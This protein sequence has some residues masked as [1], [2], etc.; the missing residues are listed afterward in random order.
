MI[1]RK[2]ASFMVMV[3]LLASLSSGCKKASPVENT[4]SAPESSTTTESTTE[5]TSA[6]TSE[7]SV[8]TTATT[9][10]TEAPETEDTSETEPSES[11]TEPSETSEKAPA[12][13]TPKET[14]ETT[15]A[16]E[17][18][19]DG[20]ILP[21]SGDYI[22]P[23]AIPPEITD[24]IERLEY[25]RSCVIN[26]TAYYDSLDNNMKDTWC[27]Q[28][29]SDHSQ[30]GSYEYFRISDYN[31]FYINKNVSDEDKVIYLTFD[32]GYASNL[33]GD[34]LDI[35]A[36][37]NAKANFFVT[38]NYLQGCSGYAIR[39]KEEG[40]LVC[41]HTVSHSDLTNKSVEEI[42][43][44][45]IDVAE[46]FY[47][48]TGYQLDPYFRPPKGNYTKRMMTIISD[49]GYKTVFWSLAYN[50]Y[51]KNKQPEPGYVLDHFT[52]YHHNGAIALM[53]NDSTSNV[54]ELDSVLTMLE[55]EGYRFGLLSEIG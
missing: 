54:S 36:A 4:V 33:T 12:E 41:N 38:K 28:R 7:T 21:P 30:S 46:Y 1:R 55:Q 48:V 31:G 5:E 24:P 17:P 47:E 18:P 23:K 49:C 29:K 32:C 10:E 52:K 9:T 15:P 16:T 35:L 53:H 13:T 44:E 26:N 20:G 51:D 19:S 6:T 22:D 34:I 8:T 37:H 45:I 43:A 3:I 14:R 50:D 40:H 11:E 25:I 27:F 2:F 39:M 42:A